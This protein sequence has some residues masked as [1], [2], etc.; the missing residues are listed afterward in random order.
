MPTPRPFCSA[1]F[2][3]QSK[4]WL[5]VSWNPPLLSWRGARGDKDLTRGQKRE[6]GAVVAQ[7]SSRCWT[8]SC[9]EAWLQKHLHWKTGCVC[10]TKEFK[11]LCSIKMPQQWWYFCYCW[12]LNSVISISITANIK[13]VVLRFSAV[14]RYHDQGKSYKGQHFTGAGLQF[15]RFSPLSSRREHG[16]VWAGMVQEAL[17][18]LLWPLEDW[19][20]WLGVGSQSPLPQWHTS[21]NKATPTPTRPYLLMVLLPGPSISTPPQ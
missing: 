10:F 15:K 16:N 4:A 5:L 3:I 18:V 1:S 17:R 8:Q 14:N 9:S 7:W 20:Q 11:I 2:R 12:K 13:V 6:T 21:S 19:L